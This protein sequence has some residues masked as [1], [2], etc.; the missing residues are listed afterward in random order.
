[1]TIVID[2]T[3]APPKPKP[4]VEFAVP[5]APLSKAKQTPVPPGPI[6]VPDEVI[7]QLLINYPIK[8][9]LIL[10][11]INGILHIGDQEVCLMIQYDVPT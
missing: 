5:K 11:Y 9:L 1:M 8:M 7:I 2:D 3:P 6:V 10:S 4:K